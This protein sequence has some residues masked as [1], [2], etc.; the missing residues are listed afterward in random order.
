MNEERCIE[1]H[2]V[3]K[4]AGSLY[5]HCD[6]SA[7][8]YLK[9]M[10]DRR[11]GRQN[12]RTEIIWKRSHAHSD[13]KQGRR[14]HGRIHDTLLYYTKSDK[15]TWNQLYTPSD[16]KYIDQFYKHIEPETGPA[17]PVHG[18]YRAERGS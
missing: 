1:T 18:H 7:S 2:R 14:Q 17:H 9:V 12:F 6:Q 11:F 5:L 13:A 10:L 15:W 8:H 3:L 4:K 16:Q